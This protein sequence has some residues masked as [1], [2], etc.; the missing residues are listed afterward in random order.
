MVLAKQTA[1]I[2]GTINRDHA[3]GREKRWYR[4]YWWFW[5]VL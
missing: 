5:K 4:G 2:V 1:L 3:V